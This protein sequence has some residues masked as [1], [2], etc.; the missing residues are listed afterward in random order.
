VSRQ[1]QSEVSE[2][3]EEMRE[4]LRTTLRQEIVKD[5]VSD[6][7]GVI[8]T[9]IK[10]SLQ[11]EFSQSEPTSPEDWCRTFPEEAQTRLSKVRQKSG[12]KSVNISQDA[13]QHLV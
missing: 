3:L 12:K 4:D 8:K 11:M 5:V 7:K 1:Q 10:E 13:Q 6:L 9:C 2:I